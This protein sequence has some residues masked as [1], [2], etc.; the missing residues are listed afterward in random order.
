MPN[1]FISDSIYVTFQEKNFIYWKGQDCSLQF[2][3][4]NQLKKLNWTNFKWQI[5][6][7]DEKNLKNGKNGF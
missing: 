6:D 1:L 2:A 4:R 5:V 7:N 3:G